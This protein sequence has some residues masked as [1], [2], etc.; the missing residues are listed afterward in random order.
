MTVH[1][2]EGGWDSRARIVD[3]R[4]LERRPRRPEVETRLMQETRLLPWLAP[5]LP[6]RVPVPVVVTRHPS[7]Y[8][9]SWS[10][11]S[12]PPR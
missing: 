1:E 11:V 5:Q 4:W 3:G 12:P 8:A 6:A 2:L 10:R 9:T 7:S